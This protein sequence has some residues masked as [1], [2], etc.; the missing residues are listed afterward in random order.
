MESATSPVG[1][2]NSRNSL[3]AAALQESRAEGKISV[4][5]HD[6]LRNVVARG[7]ILRGLIAIA[8]AWSKNNKL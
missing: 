7:H 3:G 6:F 1:S 8:R 2:T 4:S 5:S